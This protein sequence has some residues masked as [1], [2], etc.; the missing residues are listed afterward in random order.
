EYMIVS[1]SSE[2]PLTIL[3][4]LHN[5]HI[6]SALCFTKSVDSAHRLSELIRIF[7]I[8]YS[9]TLKK[10]IKEIEI[11]NIQKTNEKSDNIDFV[12]SIVAAEYSS[13]LSQEERKNILNK[14]KH[15]EIQL[16][17]CSDLIARGIDIERVDTVINYDVPIYMKKYVH[18][19]GRT[20]RA[21]RKGDAYSIVET[22]EVR[23]FKNMLRK[24]GH[25]D[26]IKNVNIKS[27]KLEPLMAI[28]KK[29]LEAFGEYMDHQPQ[30]IKISFLQWILMGFKKSDRKTK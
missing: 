25:L 13:D 12:R 30:N 19:V 29:S 10:E 15:G 11:N 9:Q 5:H 23:H 14:F 3:H 27:I 20:A 18:R 17:I 16:L 21:G 1:T 8:L 24:A 22:Q 6:S 26:K 4:L 7:E 28:Y 2:K